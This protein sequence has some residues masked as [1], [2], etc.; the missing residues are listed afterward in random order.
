MNILVYSEYYS[1]LLDKVS[2]TVNER[3]TYSFLF[4]ELF[5]RD[6]VWTVERDEN[7]ASDGEDLR[8]EYEEETGLITDNYSN[9]SMLEMLVALSIRCEDDIMG[10]PDEDNTYQWFWQMLRNLG[11]DAFTNQRWNPMQVDRILNRLIFRRYD[12]NGN[13]GLFPL[14]NP[15]ADQRGVEIWYQMGSWL[16]ENFDLVE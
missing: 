6:F 5:K 1:W 11:L 7:R 16:C 14:K 13:G 10:Y 8:K 3:Q 15:K 12:R 9:C 2:V 4:S